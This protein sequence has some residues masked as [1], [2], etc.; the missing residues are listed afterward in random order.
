VQGFANDLDP[1]FVMFGCLTPFP[2]TD[3]YNEAKGNGWIEDFNWSHYDMIHAIMSTE[4][5]SAKEVQEQL[6]DCYRS[7]YGPWKRRFQG[8]FSS[9]ALK[10]K[11]NWHMAGKGLMGQLKALF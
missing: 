4:T 11:V 6:Y 8:L 2:G 1:D 7:F 9:N 5:L 3:I 10:R